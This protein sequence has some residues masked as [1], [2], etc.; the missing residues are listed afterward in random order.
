[1]GKVIA[2]TGKGGTGKTAVSTMVVRALLN[3]GAGPIL[4]VDADPNANFHAT[5]GVTPD[6]TLGGV[7]ESQIRQPGVIPA[8]MSKP[9]Y[10]EYRTREALVEAAGFD[11]LAMGR[12]EGSGCYC[13]ANSLLRDALGRLE[14]GYSWIVVDCEAG[15]EHF[16]RRTAA[17]IDLMLIMADP[18]RRALETVGTVIELARSLATPVGEVAVAVNRCPAPPPEPVTT[19]LREL[20]LKANAFL[21][22]DP[23]VADL[24]MRG[25][26][27][28]DAG[29]T[30][31]LLR[32]VRD[33]MAQ[34]RCAGLLFRPTG[35]TR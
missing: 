3:A 21:P 9:E 20:G 17:A 19:A 2:V 6:A 10:F 1:M 11:F 31:P 16:S 15:L 8:G 13:F 30:S 23:L 25:S 29:E 7:R 33:L 22:Q 32:V 4:A 5:L 12:P 27:L 26:P 14:K 34:T 24:D 35:Q 18:S 28:L